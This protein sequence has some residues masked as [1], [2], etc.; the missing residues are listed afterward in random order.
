MPMSRALYPRDW[1]Q[2]ARQVKERADWRCQG[3]GRVD[4]P[5]PDLGGVVDLLLAPRATRGAGGL[6]RT[7]AVSRRRD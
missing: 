6:T 2:I 4:R 7:G 3:C 1:P 5:C